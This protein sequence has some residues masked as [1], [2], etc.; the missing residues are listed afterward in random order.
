MS[1]QC[2]IVPKIPATTDFQIHGFTVISFVL[3]E[4]F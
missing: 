2:A 3:T 4:P 1:T